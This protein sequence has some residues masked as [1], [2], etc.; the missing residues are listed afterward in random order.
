LGFG[1]RAALVQLE[2]E[3][4]KYHTFEGL[5]GAGYLTL[6]GVKAG[7]SVVSVTG[8]VGV[9]GDQASKFETTISYDGL[10]QQ[11]SSSDLDD[12]WFRAYVKPLEDM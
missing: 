6:D 12:C 11:T 8:L 4:R 5:N 10:I 1:L 3:A 9:T 2:V 7:E